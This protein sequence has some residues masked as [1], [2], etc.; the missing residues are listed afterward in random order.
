[1][2]C[3]GLKTHH[4]PGHLGDDACEAYNIN[5]FNDLGQT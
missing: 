5:V 3:L 4:L 1:M 2:Q